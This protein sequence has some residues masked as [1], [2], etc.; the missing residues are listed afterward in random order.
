MKKL[1]PKEL[2]QLKP[3]ID[4]TAALA[5][6]DMDSEYRCQILAPN[7]IPE[8]KLRFR[9]EGDVLK[10]EYIT[11]HGSQPMRELTKNGTEITFKAMAGSHGDE[12]F[13]TKLERYQGGIMLGTTM[14]LR[15]DDVNAPSPVV[16]YCDD[17]DWQLRR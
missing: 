13:Y 16:C 10:G 6:M 4:M 14:Q 15:T 12:L 3:N 11:E 8:H 2:M 9:Y 17:P 5:C 7:G 1:T